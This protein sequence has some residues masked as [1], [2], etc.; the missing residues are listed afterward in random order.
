[1]TPFRANLDAFWRRLSRLDLIALVLF[2][3]GACVYVLGGSGSGLS[4]I[5]FLGAIAAVYLIVRMIGWWRTRLLWRLRDRL[6]VAY[7]F[8]ALVPVLLVAALVYFTGTILYTQLGGYL[9]YVD[10][11]HR[12]EMIS[13]GAEQIATALGTKAPGISPA[14]AEQ[15]VASQEH[16]VYDRELP[17]LVVEYADDPKLLHAVA[18]PGARRFA[19]LVQQGGRLSLVGLR[20]VDT[21][22]GLRVVAL[23]VPI[24]PEFLATLAPDLG[25]LHVDVLERYD[26]TRSAS[27]LYPFG[28][29]KYSAVRRITAR[30]RAL[31]PKLLWLDPMI[32]GVSKF[33]AA[34]L[35]EEPR[36]Q[37]ADSSRRQGSAT[38]QKGWPVVA[39]F[40]A[41][42]S[43]L[44]ARIFSSIGELGIIYLLPFILVV[45]ALLIIEAAALFTGIVMTRRITTA[46]DDLYSATRYIQSGDF[47]HRVRV[48]RQDQLGVLGESFNEMT[49]SVSNLIEEK[50]RRQRL[51]NEI[52][53]AREVQNQLF[54]RQIPSVPGVEINAI[55]KAAR[56]VSGD[57]YDFIQLSPTQVAIAIADISGKGI[58][59]AL[60]MASLQAALRS[61]MLAPG[62]ETLSASELVARLNKHL[63][64]NTG[65]DRFA[66]FFIA[67]YD[68]AARTL[69]YCNAGHLPTFLLCP[70]E[71]LHLDKGGMVLGVIEDYPF[72][73]GTVDVPCDALLIGYSDGLIEPE[74]VYGEEFGIPRLEQAAIRVQNREPREVC[75]SLMASVEEWAGTPEQADDMTVIVARLR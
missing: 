15:I 35:E 6:I 53:I 45:V 72:E 41:R 3:L 73:E 10:L 29:A 39:S 36:G 54:P 58:S 47:T 30:N 70:A 28:D 64:R 75:E 22:R 44:N 40:N 60:L 18:G 50:S 65:D 52:S 49:N 67:V 1:M 69:R 5:K 25:V 12:V 27:V 23:R 32:S 17:G 46:V 11:Q 20:G 33:E 34:Y 56:A 48:D 26:S 4:F 38:L 21:P 13:D 71:T 19:G 9:L 2:L 31:Q 24:T 55:C 14:D 61:Q 59:A 66:T 68:S 16:A 37:N 51:E 7:L 42:P 43:S 62:S 8:I 57:Y 74:N 63:V